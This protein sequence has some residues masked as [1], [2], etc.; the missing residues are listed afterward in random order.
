MPYKLAYALPLFHPVLICSWSLL[1][2]SCL[3]CDHCRYILW[4]S[5]LHKETD[6]PWSGVVMNLIDYI[7][8]S[9]NTLNWIWHLFR[10]TWL[11]SLVPFFRSLLIFVVFRPLP[12]AK[13]GAGQHLVYMLSCLLVQT[14]LV[15]LRFT[16]YNL[17]NHVLYLLFLINFLF[18]LCGTKG[19][20]F[21]HIWVNFFL[22]RYM[23]FHSQHSR[24]IEFI[25]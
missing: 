25:L 23:G 11:Y 20:S 10:E 5:A 1:V 21:L 12:T 6:P 15:V 13:R 19:I 18:L 3:L 7:F 9:S 2:I 24:C 17:S 14:Y 22:G 16:L 8:S 4:A